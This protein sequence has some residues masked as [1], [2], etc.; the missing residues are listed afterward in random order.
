MDWQYKSLPGCNFSLSDLFV[1]PPVKGDRVMKFGF[2]CPLVF[3]CKLLRVLLAFRSELALAGPAKQNLAESDR[4][5]S[6]TGFGPGNR[7]MIEFCSCQ[8]Y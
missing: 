6:E 3:A 7:Q 5:S 8:C 1:T 2:D 4:E